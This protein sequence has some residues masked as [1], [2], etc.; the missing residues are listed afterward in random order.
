MA[1]T[2][3]QYLQSITDGNQQINREIIELFLLQVP[4]F[5]NNLNHLY[6]TGQYAALGKEAHKAKSSLQIMGMTEL[7]A[8]MKILSQKTIQ[9]IDAESYPAH[10]RN[11]EL[12]CAG[13]VAELQAVLDSY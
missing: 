7:E 11:F 3:L 4:D 1:Y 13:A 10:I 2:N 9:G 12:Q 8:E 6:Q 5:I